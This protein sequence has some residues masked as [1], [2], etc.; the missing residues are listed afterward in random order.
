MDPSTSQH[1]FFAVPI[2]RYS[3]T[4]RRRRLSSSSSGSSSSSSDPLVPSNASSPVASEADVPR[5]KPSWESIPSA[6]HLQQ[7]PVRYSN[8]R[9]QHLAVATT[10]LYRSLLSRQWARAERAFACLIRVRD[11]DVRRIWAVGLQLLLRRPA[12]DAVEARRLAL[13]YLERLVLFY[14]YVPRLH[15]HHPAVAAHGGEAHTGGKPTARGKG[16]QPEKQKAKAK[17]PPAAYASA[18]DFNPALFA[19]LIEGS[20]FR[21]VE[22]PEE[23]E[24][25]ETSRPEKIRE[26]L[27]ELM[28]TPP[29]SDM[30][31]LLCLR[32]M[33]CLWIAD[34]E[35]DAGDSARAGELRIEA[36]SHFGTVAE[37]GG[38]L[39]D[40]I[41]DF[42]RDNEEDEEM[43]DV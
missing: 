1:S 7:V 38:T 29:W 27:E 12:E 6:H 3:K 14:P 43:V 42:L 19:L 30:L 2:N 22:A 10:I 18:V 25:P 32:G 24:E 31:A 23:G 34:I 16:K 33:L 9:K 8:L 40:G 4:V 5:Q 37:K 35:E 17:S 41:V 28:L 20:R 39:P 26:R 21:S 13:E 36:R 11:V 15:G